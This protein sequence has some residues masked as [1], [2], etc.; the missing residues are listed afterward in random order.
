[1]EGKRCRNI[2][3]RANQS[4]CMMHTHRAVGTTTVADMTKEAHN[5][6]R[7]RSWH[8]NERQWHANTLTSD[9]TGMDEAKG[10]NSGG[11][12]GYRFRFW[13]LVGVVMAWWLW[14]K[15]DRDGDLS[16]F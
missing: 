9:I 6:T 8:L 16:L 15:N 5:Y 12:S 3:W 13:M 11:G 4:G 14:H 10:A 7:G 2:A 1:M